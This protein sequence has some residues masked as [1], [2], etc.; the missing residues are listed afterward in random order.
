MSASVAPDS[1]TLPPRF[2][3]FLGHRRIGGGSLA[4]VTQLV[5]ALRQDSP[6][7]QTL[8]AALL[9]FDDDSG[10]QVDIDERALSSAAETDGASSTPAAPSTSAAP[11][12]AA[13]RPASA[14]ARSPGRPK[15][16]VVGREVTLLPRHWDWL[17]RQPGGA[18]VALRKLVDEARRRHADEDRIR[19]AQERCYRFATA[20]A[21]DLPDYEA[22]LRALFA[23]KLAAFEAASGRWP[24]DV[25]AYARDLA[26]DA[27]E[28]PQSDEAIAGPAAR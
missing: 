22:A 10:Q 23:R 19:Q 3:A 24:A 27:F 1:G 4:A 16:G 20:M 12:V 21:G 26:R 17:G 2:T 15:L 13:A 5:A 7:P 11:S 6:T 25:R 14:A 8:S 9:V 28:P 18:S